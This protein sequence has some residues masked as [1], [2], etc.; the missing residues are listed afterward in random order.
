[1]R[2]IVVCGLLLGVLLGVSA[3]LFFTPEPLKRTHP[4]SEFYPQCYEAGFTSN[5][6]TFLR[7]GPR[8]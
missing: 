6:C 2:S 3:Y 4:D 7:D 8:S 5:Q 1:M